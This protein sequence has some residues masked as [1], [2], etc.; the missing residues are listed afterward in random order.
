[1]KKSFTILCV[2]LLLL[3]GKTW[4]QD[5]GGEE[6]FEGKNL[7]S[8]HANADWYKLMNAPETNVFEVK[9][10]YDTYF[11]TNSFVKSK[12]TRAYE[13]WT[14]H[15]VR[16][17][18]DSNGNVG[19]QNKNANDLKKKSN[20]NRIQGV[21]AN[22]T[23]IMVTPDM[24]PNWGSGCYTQGTCNMLAINPS[25]SNQMIAAFIDGGT[26]WRT[27]D[28]C[29]TWTQVGT[30]LLARHFGAVVYSKSNPLIV[31]AA[32]AQGVLKSTDGGA[33][34]TMTSYNN[35]AAYPGGNEIWTM[36]VKADDPNTVL[37]GISN[38]LYKTVDGGA[39]WT[40]VTFGNGIR[41]LRA[42]PSTPNVVL[43]TVKN[44]SW[45]EVRR[46]T[47]FGTTWTSITNGYPISIS[48]Y[49]TDLA[50]LAVTPAAPNNVWVHLICK[51]TSTGTSKT[52]DIYKSTDGGMSFAKMNVTADLT[53]SFWQGGWN[54][55]FGISDTDPNLMATGA[56][57]MFVSTNGGT[58]WTVSPNSNAKNGPHSDVHGIVIKGTAIY[59]A[60]DGG[61]FKST[62]N[63]ATYDH[64]VDN[65]I[66]SQ[67]IWGFD[68][69]W[70]SDI[71]AIGMYH[72]PST[73]RDDSIY[74]GWYPLS[75]ADAG[76]AFVNK[77]DDRYIYAHPWGDARFTRSTNRMIA[78]ASISIAQIYKGKN[79][80]NDPDYYEQVYGTNGSKVYVSTNN[81][82]GFE[83]GKTFQSNV[84]DYIVALTNNK[85]IYART[86][87]TINKTVDGGVTWTD[88]SPSSIS[89]GR[90]ISHIAVDGSNPSVIWVTFGEKQSTVK[91]GKSTDG[92]VTWTNYS[93]TVLP[94]YAVNCIASQ[95]GTAGGVYIGTDAGVYYRDNSLSDWT[96]FST[97]LPVATQGGWIKINYAKA[98]LRIAGQTG[99]WESDLYSASA[100]VAHPSTPS[101]VVEIGKPVQFVD[102][103]VCLANATYSWSFP[104]G[105]PSTSTIEKP[106]VTYAAGGDKSV[107]LTVI[108][109]NGTNSR[110]YTNFV[111][112]R[113]VGDIA[114][115]GWTVLHFDNQ[116]NTTDQAATLA[117]DSNPSTIWHTAWSGTPGYPHDIQID[118]HATVSIESFK[119]MPRQDGGTNG[120]VKGYEWYTSTDGVNWGTALL[121]DNYASDTGEKIST[122]S[123]PVSARYFRFRPTSE[124]N[125]Q[126]FASVAEIGINGSTS[127]ISAFAANKTL[128]MP[129]GSINFTDKSVGTPTSWSWSFPGGT[130]STSTAQN[131]TVTYSTEGIYPV[132]L[133]ITSA[134]G[135]DIVTKNSYINVSTFVPQTGW[136]LKYV[137]SEETS[138]ENTPATN[139]FDG[140]NSTFWGTNWSSTNPSP[141]HE[142][143]I[144]M[145]TN[146]NVNG[147]NYV[148]RQ[149][150]ANGRIANYEFY[151][152][153]D[154]VN[155]TLTNSGTWAN[156]AVEK[157]LSFTP[158]SARYIRLRALSEVNGNPWTAVGE[159]KMKLAGDLP[160][161]ANFNASATAIIAGQSVTFTDLTTNTPTSW[162]WTFTGGTPS[163]STV[164]NPTV[165][166]N[167]AGTY[168]VALTV[169]N[170]AGNNTMTKNA[171][172]TVTAPLT[173]CAS[174]STSFTNDYIKTVTVGATTKASVGST[175]SDYTST[176]IPL[177]SGASTTYS[178]APKGSSRTEYWR[179]YIDYNHNGVF[180]DAGE[181]VV[182]VNGKTTRTGSFTVLA[183]ALTGQTRMRVMQKYSTALTGPCEAFTN[184]E[185]EDYT[186]NISSNPVVLSVASIDNKKVVD[187]SIYSYR[188]EIKIDLGGEQSDGKVFIYDIMGHQV[189]TK[190]IFKGLNTIPVYNTGIYIVKVIVDNNVITRKVI[191]E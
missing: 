5:S 13:F 187:V 28:N 17:N 146:Y 68:Q 1:M 139:A 114:K 30:N 150:G 191:A 128:I 47:D 67:C 108:D 121:T 90:S 92:G 53:N 103:S 118:M 109:A 96:L 137:D 156:D 166:Y 74:T 45:W 35:T 179:V 176:V 91:V 55:A 21:T 43:A 102:M 79:D 12:E 163:T 99:I 161:V 41:D 39:S 20:T 71:M 60:G 88:V 112:A 159:I 54:Q 94:S 157:S 154:G 147:F 120:T 172:I 72:G 38:S 123:A 149:N 181:L 32:S 141:P 140:S 160:P 162:S 56:Y 85:I 36:E 16:S 164:Q 148:P 73:L 66:Q 98:K 69:G 58:S 122:L 93:G 31:Y 170:A 152:S 62:D 180:T 143:Q 174:Q 107:S 87:N 15:I 110:T 89:A 184:G 63:G 14:R 165:T 84:D 117:I 97:N 2:I 173:Y 19:K 175:Y 78:P 3:S 144:D 151:V 186:V 23:R 18:Y 106:V 188:N 46:S 127:L 44:G 48:G 101:F 124:I 51:Q 57:D 34:W 33:T 64:T 145:G 171:Y 77:G 8:M 169:T 29:V 178:L 167:T 116:Q 155:W 132:T 80:M 136:S 158:V 50:L 10:A 27:T 52:Y 59:S 37:F 86:G 111:R 126:G 125:G 138:S 6:G 189:E 82:S 61:I 190:E 65:G 11:L 185:V 131:P 75:G 182:N 76:E 142:I 81:A 104:G 119:Y 183:T 25:N 83:Q 9:K 177:T 134:S 4:S 95:M 133:S 100:P 49:T 168:A 135:T 22:W 26:L 113:T 70:K 153:A 7:K 42:L 24:V 105:T 115:T 40:N 130:P 129:G